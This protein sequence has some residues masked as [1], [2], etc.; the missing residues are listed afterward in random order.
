[1]QYFL[2]LIFYFI[3]IKCPELHDIALGVKNSTNNTY[4]SYVEYNC[5]GTNRMEDGARRRVLK[6]DAT[7]EWSDAVT[8]CAGIISIL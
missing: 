3:A 4:N 1:M 5:T 7:A 8:D 2:N 6:C